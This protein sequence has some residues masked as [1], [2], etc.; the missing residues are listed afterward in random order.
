M[1]QRR[2]SLITVEVSVFLQVKNRGKR[3]MQ[4]VC[5]MELLE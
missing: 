1:S 2:V 5:G 3:Y 4:M